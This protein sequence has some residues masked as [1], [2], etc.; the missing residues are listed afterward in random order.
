MVVEIVVVIG[1]KVIV[2]VFFEEKLVF[3]RLLGVYEIVDYFE[4]LLKDVLKELIGGVGVDVVYDLVGGDLFEKVLCVIVWEGW[5]MV[6]GFVVGEILK[7]LLNL[8]LF[9]GCDI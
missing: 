8:V 4:R 3:V 5:F 6:I 1:V 7:I 9:K 2:C